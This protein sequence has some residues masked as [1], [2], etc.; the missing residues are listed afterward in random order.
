MYEL[1]STPNSL[2]VCLYLNMGLVLINLKGLEFSPG[3]IYFPVF[4][5]N[6]ILC[7]QEV[8][9]DRTQ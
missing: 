7:Y 6:M 4:K 5:S 1:L 3:D 8:K 2:Y 9:Y